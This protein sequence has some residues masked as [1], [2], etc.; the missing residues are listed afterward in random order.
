MPRTTLA[1]LVLVLLAPTALAA[2]IAS[3]GVGPGG[4][5]V[6]DDGTPYYLLVHASEPQA[7][8]TAGPRDDCA[9]DPQRPDT[10]PPTLEHALLA[11]VNEVA[12][13]DPIEEPRV[14]GWY[15]RCFSGAFGNPLMAGA[16]S[17]DAP[18]GRYYLRVESPL[19]PT[20][21]LPLS[22]HWPASVG[23]EPI[24][25]LAFNAAAQVA[26]TGTT[27]I[28]TEADCEGCPPPTG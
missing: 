2:P 3:V 22:I 14:S 5:I 8:R 7:P 13:W 12:T 18:T 17:Y 28:G 16:V 4:R 27:G 20:I 6:Q 26:L 1:L 15:P 23:E 19:A 11:L 24:V 10:R 9:Y 25:P 21:P